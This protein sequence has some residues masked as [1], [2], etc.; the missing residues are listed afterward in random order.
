VFRV[1]PPP[2]IRW[3]DVDYPEVIDL[4]RR[5]YPDR[6]GTTLIGSPLTDPAWLAA[7]PA[8]RPALIV[9]EGVFPYLAEDAV[10]ELIDR[11]TAQLPGGELAFDGFS[12]LG[13]KMVQHHPAV[14]ATGATV[15]WSIADPHELERR[16]PRLKLAT[17]LT[18]YDPRGYDP[19]QVARMSLLSRLA[20]RAFIAIPPLA[21]TAR[22]LRYRF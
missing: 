11:L 6:E 4:R 2:G 19:R 20:I 14:R 9:A 13:L 17:S 8:D 22:L 18:A 12:R 7:V 10:P 16:I 15:H 3:F 1:D 21:R 5:L